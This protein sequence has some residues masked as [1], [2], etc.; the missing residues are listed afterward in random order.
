VEKE[1][2]S[3]VEHSRVRRQR[4]LQ[5]GGHA[6]E[7]K[8]ER[9]REGAPGTSVGSVG[10]GGNEARWS[11]TGCGRRGVSAAARR[12]TGRPGPTQCRAAWFKLGFKQFK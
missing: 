6:G 11:A 5:I 8:R 7:R 1:R 2:S 4:L 10:P 3:G 9:E 12:V